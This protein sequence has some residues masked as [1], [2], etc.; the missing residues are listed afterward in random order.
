MCSALDL[1]FGT[2]L[3]KLFF[4]GHDFLSRDQGL[5]EAFGVKLGFHPGIIA[6][7]HAK[8]RLPGEGDA[9]LLQRTFHVNTGA[10][11]RFYDLRDQRNVIL[12]REDGPGTVFSVV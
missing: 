4:G 6:A 1:R 10:F 7:G 12:F 2:L 3:R 9:F 8:R 5:P 11:D